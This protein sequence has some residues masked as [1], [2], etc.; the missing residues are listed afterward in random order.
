MRPAS[1]RSL[2]WNGVASAACAA[3][4]AGAACES[5]R[6]FDPETLYASPDPSQPWVPPSASAPGSLSRRLAAGAAAEAG[7]AGSPNGRTLPPWVIRTGGQGAAGAVAE[8]VAARGHDGSGAAAE[9]GAETRDGAAGRGGAEPVPGPDR[10]SLAELIDFALRSNPATR[11]E[12]ER[13]RAAEGALG[14]VEAKY[15]PTL[16]AV[17]YGGAEQDGLASTSGRE[18]IRGPIVGG[19][20]ELNW[21]L[22]DFGRRDAESAAAA[23]ALVAANFTFNRTLQDVVFQVQRAYFDLDARVALQDAARQNLDTAATQAEAVEERLRA[24]LATMPDHL[25]AQQRLSKARFDLEAARSDTIDARAALA[26]AVGLTADTWI[27]I[28]SLRDLPLPEGFEEG[29]DLLIEEGLAQRPDL[30]ARVARVREAAQ[31]VRRAEAEFA[32]VVSLSGAVGGAYQDYRVTNQPGPPLPPLDRRYDASMP[33]YFIGL[34]A[35]WLLFDGFSREAALRQAQAE[36]RAAVAALEAARLDVSNEVW[37]AY[38]D[39]RAARVQIDFGEALLRASQD[40]YDSVFQ[41]YLLG[42]RT[43]TDLLQAESDLDL[44]R[45]TLVR[46]R[47][48]LLAASVRLAHAMG[49][50]VP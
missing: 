50:A 37:S 47:A 12:W 2:A 26:R 17:G 13:A 11:L 44:A 14:V 30:Q 43:V 36:R 31:R 7:G 25:Q 4:F 20:L 23:Q 32:P 8:D 3:I 6:L 33:S 10:A 27:E 48:D 49:A 18:I 45:S 35:S 42:L 41:G 46:T 40:A 39:F 19:A 15:F 22:L 28:E 5:R 21:V 16:N 38:F 29:V 1:L 34:R 9:D 24:G